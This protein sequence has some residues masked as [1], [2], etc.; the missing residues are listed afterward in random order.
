MIFSI[1]AFLALLVSICIKNRKKSLLVQAL[2]CFFEA[3]YNFIICAYTGAYLSIINIIR[4]CIF[5]NKDKFNKIAYLLILIVFW[6]I[7]IINC[8]FTWAGWISLLPTIGTLIRTYCLWQSNMKLV[9]FSGITTGLL[10]GLYYIY[11]KS[12]FMALGDLVL[13]IVAIFSIY[14]NDIKLKDKNNI[15]IKENNI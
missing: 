1:L 10:Y 3:T 9:R 13:L 6:G 2:N 8:T 15:F 4:T 12:W 11:Y 5:I 7:I 14:N